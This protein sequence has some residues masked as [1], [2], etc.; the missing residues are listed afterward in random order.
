MIGTVTKFVGI[1]SGRIG[2]DPLG[3]QLGVVWRADVLNNIL[4][5]QTRG[6]NPF[7]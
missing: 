1:Y 2:D 4:S 7:R 3:L 5:L 6:M